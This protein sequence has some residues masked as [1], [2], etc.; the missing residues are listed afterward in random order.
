MIDWHETHLILPKLDITGQRITGRCMTAIL[1]NKRV[2]R[3]CTPQELDE[4]VS[5]DA[6]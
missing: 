3:V 1:N 4:H 5:D 6:W 2:Y